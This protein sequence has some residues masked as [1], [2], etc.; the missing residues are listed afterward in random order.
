LDARHAAEL[1]VNALVDALRVSVAAQK[2]AEA[3]NEKLQEALRAQEGLQKAAA[4]A[5]ALG[6]R[7]PGEILDRLTR[8]DSAAVDR[9]K[10]DRPNVLLEV[11]PEEVSADISE[12]VA[13]L[14][15]ASAAKAPAA[16]ELEVPPKQLNTPSRSG[17]AASGVYDAAALVD[18]AS[19]FGAASSP[20]TGADR[21]CSLNLADWG[22]SSSPAVSPLL[23]FRSGQGTLA[24]ARHAI[25]VP[26]HNLI[27]EALRPGA[28]SVEPRND[29]D[30]DEDEEDDYD[31]D[32][33]WR[34]G[35]RPYANVVGTPV[36]SPSSGAPVRSPSKKANGMYSSPMP[37]RQ[38]SLAR[39]LAYAYQQAVEGATVPT[40][41]AQPAPE[42]SPAERPAVRPVGTLLSGWRR[43]ESEDLV[44]TLASHPAFAGLNERPALSATSKGVTSQ[45]VGSR[46]VVASPNGS[47]PMPPS[48][49]HTQ[50]SYGCID[51]EIESID[52]LR[53]RS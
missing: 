31:Y 44:M 41:P 40:P 19:V 45:T 24:S 35:A 13:D 3:T 36:R 25:E 21:A 17:T 50:V 46:L 51:S 32:E 53:R 23:L 37:V 26:R 9:L 20:G 33:S 49:F 2:A 7:Q 11:T 1:E 42:E 43:G 39:A 16:A 30:G 10:A 5:K 38:G 14:V 22:L 27:D 47:T 34:V 29:G 48:L 28:L 52:P 15:A 6:P 8:E 12:G 4:A 18:A